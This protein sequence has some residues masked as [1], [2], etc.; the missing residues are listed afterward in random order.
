MTERIR[1]ESERQK[2]LFKSG[3]L[4]SENGARAV[5]VESYEYVPSDEV[6]ARTIRRRDGT[7]AV[8]LLPVSS[9]EA[10]ANEEAHSTFDRIWL[11]SPIPPDPVETSDRAPVRIVDL[12]SG[13][14]GMT[15]GVVEAC[16]ALGFRARPV[17]ALDVDRD[18]LDVYRTNFDG[19]LGI[20]ARVEQLLD[21]H[22]GQDPTKSERRLIESL[23][24]VD[25]LVGG[26]PCQGHSD[27]NNHTRRADPKNALFLKMARF[28]ELFA[29]D[30]VIVENVRGILHDRDDVFRRTLQ[31]IEEL[32][33][34]AYQVASGVL[35]AESI[36][37]AQSRHRVFLVASR[38]TDID[39]DV[40]AFERPFRT[41]SRSF[42]WACG[43]LKDSAVTGRGFDAKSS[44]APRTQQRI[45]HLHDEKVYELPDR[46]RPPCHRD[47]AHNYPSVYGRMHGDRPSP[48]IT[49]GFTAM[50]QGR[51]VHPD[52]KRTI[53][54][55]EAARLQ[56]FP[57]FF[58][59]GERTRNAYKTMIGNA[60]PPKMT[61]VLALQLLR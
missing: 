21:G 41:E 51:F 10:I 30:H 26:P 36:G 7:E 8:S 50:G 22:L 13:C 48:T 52:K 37:V 19:A 61:Y 20:S 47:K 39:L 34:P 6:I 25:V 44:P 53:T 17:M 33:A 18:A 31:Y 54:P 49:T 5:R 27:L 15:L 38:W 32:R 24:T 35:K 16:R 58:R 4:H 57:D 29:P 40:S 3:G 42:D 1:S 43:D 28:T 45:D 12:F 60:V 46:L 23:G 56:F 11:R 9:D 55:H 14:G 2:E 59:F